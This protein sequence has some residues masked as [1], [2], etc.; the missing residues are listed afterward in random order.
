MNRAFVGHFLVVAFSIAWGQLDCAS[1]VGPDPADSV[2]I[3]ARTAA[4][5]PARLPFALGGTSPDGHR[6]SANSRFLLRDGKPWFPI[7]GEFHYSRYPA[8]RWEEEILKM[9]AGGIQVISTYIFWIH[10]EEIEGEFDWSGQRDLRRFVQLCQ[11]HG[12]YVWIRIGPW[13]H[14][15]VRNGGLPDWVVK[16]GP[17]RRNDPTYLAEVQTLY[18]QIGEQLKGMLWKDGGPVIGIQLENEYHEI[19]PGA[20][21]EHIEKLKQLAVAAGLDVPLYTITGW[22]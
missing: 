15:E 9:K 7:V 16:N 4:P 17:T 19:G 2:V 8:D 20:G 6:F 10:H 18:S 21:A 13:A 11:K 14:G 3:D 5:P 1:Q 12:L 22:D